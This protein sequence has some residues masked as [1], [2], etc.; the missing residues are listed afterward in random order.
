M[1]LKLGSYFGYSLILCSIIIHEFL[2][3]RTNLGLKVCGWVGVFIPP[4][5]GG[6]QENTGVTLTVPYYC[7]DIEPYLSL[8]LKANT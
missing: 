5:L 1:G 4:L 6:S 8:F 2:V 7:G 3:E